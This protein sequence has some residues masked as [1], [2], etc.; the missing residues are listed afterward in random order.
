MNQK[1]KPFLE[2]AFLTCASILF[3]AALG[4]SATIKIAGAKLVKLPIPLQKSF[5]DLDEKALEP[6]KVINKDKIHNKDIVEALGTR[7]YIQWILEDPTVDDTNP[8]KYCSLFLTYYTGNPDQVPHVPEECYLGGG[9]QPLRQPADIFIPITFN[10]KQTE[11]P[12]RSLLFGEKSTY[13]SSGLS[14]VYFFKVNGE[15]APNRDSARRVLQTNLLGKYSYFSKVEWR[16]F[17]RTA[18]GDIYP[19]DKSLAE[20]SRKLL[21]KL[22]PLLEKNHWPDWEKAK[23]AK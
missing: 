23:T 22:V 14:V 11:I 21:S 13:S 2:P 12:V 19:D 18:S 1:I 5:D 16:F 7:D 3:V 20:A 9:K 15:Y 8:A 10:G 6:Y 17:N 4:M